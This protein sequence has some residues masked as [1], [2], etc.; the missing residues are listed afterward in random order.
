MLPAA[1]GAAASLAVPFSAGSGAGG[2]YA[3]ASCGAGFVFFGMVWCFL[4]RPVRAYVFAHEL[5]HAVAGIICGAKI[6]RMKVSSSGGSV[7]VSKSN[8]FITLAPYFFPLYAAVLAAAAVATRL[9]AGE[10]PFVPAW[11]FA[12][13][14]LWG[15]HACFTFSALRTR[16]PDIEEYG[17]TLSWT[18]IF[19]ANALLLA[20]SLSAAASMPLRAT[21]RAAVSASVEAYSAIWRVCRGLAAEAYASFR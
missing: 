18:F 8:F 6:G 1:W 14:F 19:T 11:L 5:S 16:Q 17:K 15:F 21:A 7:Q 3:V 9:A 2:V 13:G 10:L 20:F 12:A 4:P